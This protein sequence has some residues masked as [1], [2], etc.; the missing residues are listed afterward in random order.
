MDGLYHRQLGFP[1]VPL[2]CGTFLLS[3]TR[4]ALKEA[5]TDC[6]SCIQLPPSLQVTPESIVEIEVKQKTVVKVLVRI[7]YSNDFDLCLVLKP[8]HLWATVLTVWLNKRNDQ[9][10]TLNIS[11]Y[12]LP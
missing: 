7:E 11:R 3:Y 8:H 1:N 12:K 5:L 4:H 10:S 2:P 9:H 6:Y